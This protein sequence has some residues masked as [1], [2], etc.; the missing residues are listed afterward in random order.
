M[1]HLVIRGL[2]ICLGFLAS[3]HPVSAIDFSIANSYPTGHALYSVVVEIGDLNGDGKLD[4]IIGDNDGL[5]IRMGNG[6]GTFG[7]ATSLA[8]G[9]FIVSIATGDFNRDGKLDLAATNIDSNRNNLSILLGAGNGTFAPSA[10][11]PSEQTD[12]LLGS[13]VVSDLNGDGAVDLAMRTRDIYNIDSVAIR[14]GDGSGGFG[15]LTKFGLGQSRSPLEIVVGDFN[16]DGKPDLAT[17]N[18]SSND[19]SILIG[20]GLGGLEAAY[21]IGVGANPSSLAAGD[22]NSDGKLDLVTVNYSSQNITTLLGNGAGNFSSFSSHTLGWFPNSAVL[23]DFNRDGKLDL[24]TLN[25]STGLSIMLGDGMGDFGAGT[26][27][28]VGLAPASMAAADINRDGI[29]DLAIEDYHSN[30][31]LI[32]L[33]SDTDLGSAGEVYHEYALVLWNHY[34]SKLKGQLASA[35]YYYFKGLG[36]Y[37]DFVD[38]G[39]SRT[40]L[41][42]YYICG[43]YFNYFYYSD[44]GYTAYAWYAH[45]HWLALGYGNLYAAEGNEALASYYYSYYVEAANNW[46]AYWS[47]RGYQ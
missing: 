15:A 16:G 24:A 21:S 8:L 30:Q 18:F 36:Y 43:A 20:N 42:Y 5:N 11:Y 14:L 32:L 45:F 44:A 12:D 10:N 27:F 35:W 4:L 2:P 34:N 47:A 38:V 28:S 13:L 9:S 29:L 37:Y 23:R 25:R 33:G 7:T 26:A 3:I 46:Y 31:V 39:S 6:D 17:A 22:L 1:R 19:V 41:A 40:G